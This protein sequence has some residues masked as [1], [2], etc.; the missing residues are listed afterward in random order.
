MQRIKERRYENIKQIYHDE[1][2]D[3]NNF[4]ASLWW[5]MSVMDLSD[6]ASISRG[7]PEGGLGG[8]HDP[9]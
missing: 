1:I 4:K 8:G 9:P 5:K 3:V 6:F 2:A 7:G